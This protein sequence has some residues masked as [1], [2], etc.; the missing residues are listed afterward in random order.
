MFRAGHG[1]GQGDSEIFAGLM[2]TTEGTWP[3]LAAAA[4]Q[5]DGEACAHGTCSAQPNHAHR[6]RSFASPLAARTA[7]KARCSWPPRG[8]R[9]TQ[10]E[11]LIQG[12]ECP[13]CHSS[14]CMQAKSPR[15]A[16]PFSQTADA[17][18]RGRG[19]ALSWH[20]WRSRAS[21]TL[22]EALSRQRRIVP[23]S[24]ADPS[25]R[26]RV[27]PI[28]GAAAGPHSPRRSRKRT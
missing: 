23:N 9:V 1:A 8:D 20:F 25:H 26:F 27:S 28:G 16:V 7:I 19:V 12:L 5:H 3:W 4:L 10:A 22:V 15:L 18:G 6:R 24:Q 11:L 21:P 13:V 14:A 17:A 2:G